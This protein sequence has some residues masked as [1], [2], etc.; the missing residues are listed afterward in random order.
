MRPTSVSEAAIEYVNAYNSHDRDRL[1]RCYDADFRVM[2][3]LWE[4]EKT[5]E[6]TVEVLTH[7]WRTLPGVRFELLNLVVEQDTAV[8][9]FHVAWDDPT[10]GSEPVTRRLPVVDVFNIRG[11]RLF[12]LRAYMDATQFGQWL[13]R[14]EQHG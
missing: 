7:V 12:R 11:G 1:A 9:E 2:N 3:P 8:I 10:Q 14:M 13:D 6:E 4:G 5:T